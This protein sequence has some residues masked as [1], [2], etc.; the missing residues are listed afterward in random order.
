MLVTTAQTL[1]VSF[2]KN[3]L[4]LYQSYAG[5]SQTENLSQHKTDQHLTRHS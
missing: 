3:Y 2:I 5:T 1:L 4:Q